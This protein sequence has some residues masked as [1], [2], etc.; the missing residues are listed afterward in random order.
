M[1]RDEGD[2]HLPPRRFLRARGL[3]LA[4]CPHLIRRKD[5]GQSPW[6]RHSSPSVAAR[7]SVRPIARGYYNGYPTIYSEIDG[8]LRKR[9][10]IFLTMGLWNTAGFKW[11]SRD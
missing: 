11:N 3:G 6:R 7:T 1:Q 10:A 5:L 9:G 4:D 8:A 2:A